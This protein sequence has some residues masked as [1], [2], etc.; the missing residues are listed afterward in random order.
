LAKRIDE[1]QVAAEAAA[2]KAVQDRLEL[3]KANTDRTRVGIYDP[4]PKIVETNQ[5]RKEEMK[6]PD[7]EAT[8]DPRVGV[9]YRTRGEKSGSSWFGW[10]NWKTGEQK[11]AEAAQDSREGKSS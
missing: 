11:Q 7:D 8:L 6:R 9:F 2:A 4:D 1:K 3:E 10:L 5:K